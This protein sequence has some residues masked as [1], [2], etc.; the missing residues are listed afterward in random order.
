MRKFNILTLGFVVMG[1]SLVIACGGGEE[2][3]ADNNLPTRRAKMREVKL[4]TDKI[5]VSLKNESLSGVAED[6][7]KIQNALKA[8]VEL[9]PVEHKEKYTA[10]NKEA[11]TVAMALASAAKGGNIKEANKQFRNLVPYCGKCHEDCAFMLAPA[12]PEYEE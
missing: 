4:S 12:F 11:Q 10:Y 6:A 2:Q 3:M 5:M 8:V 1:L 9:Y 7:E